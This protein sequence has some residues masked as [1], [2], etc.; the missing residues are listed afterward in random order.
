M[1]EIMVPKTCWANNKFCN[2]EPSV[3]SNWPFY[4]HEV[5]LPDMGS[6]KVWCWFHHFPLHSQKFQNPALSSGQLVVLFKKVRQ[7]LP[8]RTHLLASNKGLKAL[9][10]SG[11]GPHLPNLPNSFVYIQLYFLAVAQLVE[12]LSYKPE[13]PGFD[14]WCCRWKFSLA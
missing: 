11:R 3:A 2:K 9:P 10:V 6:R 7:L 4:F 13:G 1:M 14:S 12:A 8:V 5:E